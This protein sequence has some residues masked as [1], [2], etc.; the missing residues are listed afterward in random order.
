MGTRCIITVEAHSGLAITAVIAANS[1]IGFIKQG[2]GI[3]DLRAA[4]TYTGITTVE[5][6]PAAG[7]GSRRKSWNECARHLGGPGRAARD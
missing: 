5:A 3:L 2:E 7:D 6:G 4:N 1:G